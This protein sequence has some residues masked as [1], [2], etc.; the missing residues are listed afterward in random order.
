M[1]P[2]AFTVRTVSASAQKAIFDV[3]P[4]SLLSASLQAVFGYGEKMISPLNG[5]YGTFR[6]ALSIQFFRV[7]RV[8]KTGAQGNG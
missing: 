2:I 7:G 3:T 1:C 4:S 6:G 5:R 8:G